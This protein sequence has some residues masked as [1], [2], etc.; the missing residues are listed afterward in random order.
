MVG[1]WNF[2]LKW[3]LL[4]GHVHL[5]GGKHRRASMGGPSTAHL[6]N[7]SFLSTNNLNCSES[8][9]TLVWSCPQKTKTL[10]DAIISQHLIIYSMMKSN[11]YNH[12]LYIMYMCIM[13]SSHILKPSSQKKKHHPSCHLKVPQVITSPVHL[14][15][16][17][18][19]LK[20]CSKLTGRCSAF[21]RNTQPIYQYEVWIC[22][23]QGGW[24]DIY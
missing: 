13:F 3:F 20:I 23:G 16:W 10:D 9:P 22:K 24:P 12:M 21:I 2:L 18:F 6:A 15:L 8:Q 14:D 17:R 1:R 5:W 19:R 11:L 4:W 7:K